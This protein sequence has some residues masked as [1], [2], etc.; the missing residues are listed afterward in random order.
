MPEGMSIEVMKRFNTIQTARPSTF[1]AIRSPPAVIIREEA[2]HDV[3]YMN[4]QRA[5]G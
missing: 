1:S 5:E 2:A 4:L 3:Y